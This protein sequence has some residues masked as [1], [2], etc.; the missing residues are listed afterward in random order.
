MIAVEFQTLINNGM[1]KLPDKYCGR[2][3][4][5]VRVIVLIEDTVSENDKIEELL[6]SPLQLQQFIPF[7]RNEIYE[8]L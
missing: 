2:L 8:C 1:I 4:G 5:T 3:T 6:A 7:Q